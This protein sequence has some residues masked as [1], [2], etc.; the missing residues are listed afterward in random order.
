MPKPLPKDLD[1]FLWVAYQ[2]NRPFLRWLT[3][4][5]R[6]LVGSLSIALI[7]AAVIWAVVAFMMFWFHV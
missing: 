7:L 6:A 5:R 1:W 2:L 4:E 3:P